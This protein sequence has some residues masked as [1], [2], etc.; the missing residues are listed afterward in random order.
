MERVLKRSGDALVPTQ[1]ARGV[2]VYLREGEEQTLLGEI[3]ILPQTSIAQVRAMIRDELGVTSPYILKKC[4]I[5]LPR[6]I[7]WRKASLFFSC[8]D[9]SLIV[10]RK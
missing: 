7:D 9:E 6:N 10:E 5:P 1:V 4:N 8:D 3:I 2:L